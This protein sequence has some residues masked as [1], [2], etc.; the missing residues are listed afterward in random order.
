[1]ASGADEILGPLWMKAGAHDRLLSMIGEAARRLD[2]A[3]KSPEAAG[4]TRVAKI[5]D[6]FLAAASGVVHAPLARAI[7][8]GHVHHILGEQCF[9]TG[10]YWNAMSQFILAATKLEEVS[11]D[12]DADALRAFYLIEALEAAAFGTFSEGDAS[13]ALRVHG[14]E[15]GLTVRLLRNWPTSLPL[16]QRRL[17]GHLYYALSRVCLVRAAQ[18]RFDTYETPGT[19]AGASL[20]MAVTSWLLWSLVLDRRSKAVNPMWN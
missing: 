12:R 5:Y 13:S 19:R 18:Y 14:L 1:M 16:L 3:Y 10:R 8:F 9:F 17:V 11:A 2:A 20:D 15:L 7:T 4:F 6:E